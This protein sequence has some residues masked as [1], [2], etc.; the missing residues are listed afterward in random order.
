VS[1]NIWDMRVLDVVVVDDHP[2]MRE[3][4]RAMLACAADIRVVGDAD[5]AER[6]LEVVGKTRPDIVLLDLGLPRMSGLGCL[7][8]L[9]VE[10]PRV[11][12]V[13]LSADDDP[14]TIEIAL[15]R[16]AQAFVRKSVNP[17][18]LPAVLRQV[19]DH[20]VFHA[21]PLP[22]GGPGS[23]AK[24]AGLSP[25]ELDVLEQ[26]TQGRS[27]KQISEALWIT[28]DTVKFHLRHIYKK[29]GV[30]SRTEALRAAHELAL[31]VSAPA[32]T[33]P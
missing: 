4:V 17:D 32:P 10:H 1:A 30:G 31:V 29:L 33:R 13:V 14:H 26:I 22:P 9:R 8:R 5:S 19:A 3:A 2:L 28:Q 27:N 6:G 23:A 11:R 7:E 18:D 21:T 25:K 12:V 15:R 20:T 16:G 24:S